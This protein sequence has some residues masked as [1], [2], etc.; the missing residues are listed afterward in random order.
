MVVQYSDIDQDSY[1]GTNGNIRVTP[2]FV[3]QANHNF[4]LQSG[5]VCID[6]GNNDAEYLPA[7][8]LDGNN[9]IIGS[10]VDMGVYER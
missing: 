6:N 8:D 4:H 10:Q 5:T 1:E 2:G 3:D 9:R 7:T